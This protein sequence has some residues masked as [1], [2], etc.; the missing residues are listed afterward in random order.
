[1][2]KRRSA[3]SEELTNIGLGCSAPGVATPRVPAAIKVQ[4]PKWEDP[5]A[6]APR[7]VRNPESDAS[8]V[9]VA[10]KLKPRAL[11]LKRV[12]PGIVDRSWAL[13][14][15]GW[16]QAHEAGPAAANML[17]KA[18][19]LVQKIEALDRPPTGIINPGRSRKLIFTNGKELIETVP[20][21]T[22]MLNYRWSSNACGL[23]LTDLLTTSSGRYRDIDVARHSRV[24]DRCGQGLAT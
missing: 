20:I 18:G 24:F 15:G 12:V 7:Y 17:T 14:S 11:S 2:I 10:P 21:S 13:E 4:P 22:S 23:S 1:M 9:W 19:L 5:W 16:V 8:H 6:R 3:C